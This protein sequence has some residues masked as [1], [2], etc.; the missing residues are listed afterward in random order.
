MSER[1]KKENAN[2][3]YE[4]AA[5]G[6]RNNKRNHDRLALSRAL[7]RR[8]ADRIANHLLLHVSLR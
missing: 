1:Q 3:F 5:H 8:S 7:D 4:P 2:S 6:A